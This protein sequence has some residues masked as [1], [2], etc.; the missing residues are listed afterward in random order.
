MLKLE[1]KT[2]KTQKLCIPTKKEEIII[3]TVAN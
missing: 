1:Q 2:K 3:A